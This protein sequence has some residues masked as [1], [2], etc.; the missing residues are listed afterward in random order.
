MKTMEIEPHFE[1]FSLVQNV[2]DGVEKLFRELWRLSS[3]KRH[4]SNDDTNRTAKVALKMGD[5]WRKKFF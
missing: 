2:M 5:F 1:M 3:T 4:S